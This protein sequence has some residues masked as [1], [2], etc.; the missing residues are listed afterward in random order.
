[1]TVDTTGLFTGESRGCM[2]VS[3][4][5]KVNPF[6][7]TEED[8]DIEDIAHALSLICRYGGHCKQFYS[9][10]DHSIRVSEIVD[11]KYKLAALLHDAAEAY[12]GDNIRPVKYRLPVLQKVEDEILPVIMSRFGIKWDKK[13]QEAVKKADNI[14]GATEGRDLMYHGEDWGNLPEPL[15]GTIIPRSPRASMNGFLWRFE[16]YGG[17]NER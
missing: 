4:G 11:Y 15:E 16:E 1:M 13:V 12:I 10:A 8:I 7:M 6:E 3:S 9:V 14:V 17:N 2:E 5:K